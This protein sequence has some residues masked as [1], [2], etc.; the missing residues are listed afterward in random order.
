MRNHITRAKRIEI[1]NIPL[2]K[3]TR[4]P[5]D[6]TL[7]QLS[8]NKIRKITALPNIRISIVFFYIVVLL[9]NILFLSN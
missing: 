6:L 1:Q 5:P 8:K 3:N 2:I 4:K 7:N 9:F